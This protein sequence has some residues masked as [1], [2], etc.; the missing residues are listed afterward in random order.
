[1]CGAHT[2]TAW[3]QR[4]NITFFVRF[5]CLC[6]VASME[7]RESYWR[8]ALPVAWQIKIYCQCHSCTLQ[9]TNYSPKSYRP[10]PPSSCTS[11]TSA[12]S[13]V[14]FVETILL[15]LDCFWMVL[16]LVI[17]YLAFVFRVQWHPVDGVE[18]HYVKK[19][20]DMRHIKKL[21]HFIHFNWNCFEWIATH[22]KPTIPLTV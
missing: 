15:F 5:G 20:H 12:E 8:L 13:L 11:A 19:Q 14:F 18:C 7:N 4:K 1:M 3:A 9:T 17:V 6:C 16:V 10:P 2:D 21:I 22:L